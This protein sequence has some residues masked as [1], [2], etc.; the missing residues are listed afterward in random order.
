MLNSLYLSDWDTVIRWYEI[1]GEGTPL[2]LLPALSCSAILNF[3]PMLM[4]PKLRHRRAIMI[5]YIGSGASGHSQSFGYGLED[6]AAAIAAV[7]DSAAFGPADFL[8]HS[9]GG[10]VAISL[11]F[12]RPDLMSR[13]I[14]AEGN[15]T[16][17]GGERTRQIASEPFESFLNSGFESLRSTMAEAAKGG[18]AIANFLDAARIGVDPRGL[19]RISTALVELSDDFQDRFLNLDLETHF[20]WSERNFPGNTGVVT[21]DAPDPAL[22]KAHGVGIHVVPGVGH[23]MMVEDPSASAR[24]VAGILDSET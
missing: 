19:H 5:D 23:T 1:P 11:A 8:G 20:V 15:L 22:L 13:L 7:C 6:H 14:V 12:S 24:L 18:H 4:Q 16:P 3:L 2:V 10:S 9:Q 17:G 21:P